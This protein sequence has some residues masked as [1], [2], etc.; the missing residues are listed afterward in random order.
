MLW[1]HWWNYFS[2][3]LILQ[4]SEKHF[5]SFP[6]F[7]KF[8]NLLDIVS[9]ILISKLLSISNNVLLWG[10][11]LLMAKHIWGACIL[12]CFGHVGESSL[13]QLT[14]FLLLVF[15]LDLGYKFAFG[16]ELFLFFFFSKHCSLLT[17]PL[18]TLKH[19]KWNTPYGHGHVQSLSQ[20]G[21]A[22][23]DFTLGAPSSSVRGICLFLVLR[24]YAGSPYLVFSHCM[25]DYLLW[26]L[27]LFG[28]GASS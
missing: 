15:F 9:F 11:F 26:L 18:T 21:A 27:I 3:F 10:T 8:W 24:K 19:L 14:P 4:H 28:T 20:R 23:S 12:R 16:S 7:F 17:W 13:N 1:K 25:I 22:M 6:P 2:R 5:S